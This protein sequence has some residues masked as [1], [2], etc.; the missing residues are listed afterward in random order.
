[1]DI[2][3]YIKSNWNSLDA[4]TLFE[5]FPKEQLREE[6]EEGIIS[7]LKEI[8]EEEDSTLIGRWCNTILNDTAKFFR[9]DITAAYWTTRVQ[10]SQELENDV[11]N[12]EHSFRRSQIV[13]SRKRK[14][15]KGLQDALDKKS[16]EGSSGDSSGLGEK[17]E[18]DEILFGN[19]SPGTIIKNYA[20]KK[21]PDYKSLSDKEKLVVGLCA[22]G[23]IDLSSTDDVS[24][25]ML[26]SN[27][28]WNIIATKYSKVQRLRKKEDI[29][30]KL[31][32]INKQLND[33]DLNKAYK[34]ARSLECKNLGS[35]DEF[36]YAIYA[37]I[38][39]V[40]RK[41]K[42]ILNENQTNST[43]YDG[44]A[45]IWAEIFEDAFGSKSRILKWGESIGE[46]T[47][48]EMEKAGINKKV[49][50]YKVDC[51]IL[52][53]IEEREHDLLNCEASR[54]LTQQKVLDDKL[55]LM[56]ETKC[57][58][59]HLIL[60]CP[61]ANPCNIRM[62]YL[63]ACANKISV[64]SLRV[65]G[66]GI[67]IAESIGNLDIPISV[68]KF[69]EKSVEWFALLKSVVN[70]VIKLETLA[71]EIEVDKRGSYSQ[72]FGEK[73]ENFSFNVYSLWLR[74]FYEELFTVVALFKGGRNS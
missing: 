40:Y 25:K 48:D 35:P 10:A 22:N 70:N 42:E 29:E 62:N 59:D 66:P 51:R 46:S 20:E 50:G 43:E 32:D 1:M 36:L 4:I 49:K 33:L 72:F 8:K 28:E 74:R 61:N 68:A 57:N 12:I 16:D 18:K 15:Y 11:W 31:K 39:K 24:Q 73:E 53:L 56:L 54:S 63:Q 2:K 21:L 47:K 19:T 27:D 52:T 3:L 45:K 69:K 37:H 26:F 60:S 38:L 17:V 9:S 7:I 67:Y 14:A 58:L 65:V 64:N 30:K 6:A 71:A 41:R 55:K 44:F 23:I 5:N 13:S 34:K